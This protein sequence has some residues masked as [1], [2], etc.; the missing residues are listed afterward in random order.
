MTVLFPLRLANVQVADVV[1]L[2]AS[3]PP[4]AVQVPP[5][6]AVEQDADAQDAIVDALGYATAAVNTTGTYVNYVNVGCPSGV[7]G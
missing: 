2:P 7:A 1:P 3:T 5:Q 6:D 4:A